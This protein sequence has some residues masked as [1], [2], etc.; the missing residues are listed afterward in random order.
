MSA[1]VQL[2][3]VLL[4]GLLFGLV[5]SRPSE[6]ATV[7]IGSRQYRVRLARTVPEHVLGLRGVERLAP[8]RGMAFVYA[9]SAPRTFTMDGVLIPLD[10]VWVRSG[11]VVGLTPEAPPA[12]LT[13]GTRYP[14]PEPVNLVVELPGGTVAADALRVGDGVE[15]GR[16]RNVDSG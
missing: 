2:A 5:T 15:L 3:L 10:F 9:D 12:G 4:T 1:R 6:Q 8:G 16:R 7:R 11:R 14:S 13:V